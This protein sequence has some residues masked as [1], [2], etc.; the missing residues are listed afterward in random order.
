VG[1][2]LAIGSLWLA[3]AP[4]WADGLPA[5][6]AGGRLV[7]PNAPAWAHASAGA[8]PSD[9]K[10]NDDGPALVSG[11]WTPG[12]D[13]SHWN[14]TI[15]WAKV[16]AS[17]IRFVIM[18]ATD[19]RSYVDP[20]FA[21]NKS[22]A[23]AAGIAVGAYHFA[24]PDTTAGDAVAEADHY[25]SVARLA[26]GNIIPV[27]D[28]E[29]RTSLSVSARIAWVQAWLQEVRKK[30]HVHPMIY[31]GPYYWQNY[32]GDTQLFAEQ[33][34]PL[35]LAHWTTGTP[36][37]PGG[38]WAGKGWTVWQWSNCG[39]IPGIK[40]CVDRDRLNGS[41][42]RRIRIPVLSVATSGDGAVTSSPRGIDCGTRCTAV[43][44][45]GT[46]VSLTATPQP[47]SQF[48]GWGGTCTGSAEC[49]V[50]LDRARTVTA[51]FSDDV[52][53]TAIL[54]GPKTLTGPTR[55]TFSEVVH[56]ISRVNLVERVSGQPDA[57]PASITCLDQG[58]R[59]VKCSTGAVAEAWLLPES[60]RVPGQRY[61]VELNP[62]GAPPV[63]D[64]GGNPAADTSAT[65]RA[66]T[67]VDDPSRAI[68]ARWRTLWNPRALGGSYVLEHRDGARATYAFSGSS[69]TWYS[70]AG[71]AAGQAAIRV[72]GAPRGRFDLS[73]R[74]ARFGVAHTF[75]GLGPGPH[76]LTVRSLGM[77]GTR[78]NGTGVAVDGFEA[79]GSVDE[80]PDLT[81]RWATR[82][83][84][85]AR[86]G[87]YS[88]ADLRGE[89]IRLRFRGT[90]VDWVTA[91]GPGQGRAAVYVDGV[92]RAVVDGYAPVA[93]FGVK[94]RV[95]G[96][97]DSIHLLRIVVL[98]TKRPASHGT[99]V[100]IDGFQVS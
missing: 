25:I 33:G 86:G 43:F 32:M 84:G 93:T 10:R 27:L 91:L 57:E 64:G 62:P 63:V 58:S 50:T 83:A 100:A 76:R 45:P 95:T 17:G 19:G 81:Y 30:L 4:V 80:A 12:V 48:S 68:E 34:Y 67:S 71:P 65:F 70:I 90:E 89:T 5:P 1:L 29:E 11:S 3:P 61:T 72:D 6:G 7:D 8:F 38:R 22:G 85:R 99:A 96:L 21:T 69:I 18:K 9:P 41:S 44:D 53:P 75:S 97:S 73:A 94:R 66:A 92:R 15:G 46:V 49:S 31:S 52:P 47:G 26:P 78:G 82:Q 55:A 20:T 51:A 56:G 79:G 54:H 37:V 24:R 60:P 77:P 74:R 35:W 88:V 42:L 23:A 59:I 40:G 98:G 2:F 87:S 13:V 16:A 39:S 28:I 14:G 36:T